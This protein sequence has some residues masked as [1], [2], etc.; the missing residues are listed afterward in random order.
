MEGSFESKLERLRERHKHTLY[1]AKQH[2]TFQLEQFNLY[3]NA[4]VPTSFLKWEED[5]EF[6][7]W[8]EKNK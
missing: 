5:E 4:Y 3:G 8:L 2:I 6:K 1:I 7:L